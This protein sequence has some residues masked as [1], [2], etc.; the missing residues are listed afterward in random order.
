LISDN[1]VTVFRFS[2]IT[3]RNQNIKER[4]RTQQLRM[5]KAEN[6]HPEVEGNWMSVY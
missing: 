6:Q 5:L 4:G 3:V 2:A 1:D